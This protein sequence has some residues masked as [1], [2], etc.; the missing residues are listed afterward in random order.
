MVGEQRHRLRVLQKSSVGED[1]GVRKGGDD[2]VQRLAAIWG[3][4]V[5]VLHSKGRE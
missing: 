1:V 3:L 2:Y 5:S 4:V